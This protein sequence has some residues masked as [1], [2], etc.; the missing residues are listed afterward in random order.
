MIR[1]IGAK[2]NVYKGFLDR[3]KKISEKYGIAIQVMNAKLV[4]GK[5]HL[6]SAVEHAQRS[7]K[8][9]SNATNSLAMEILLYASGERQ[10]QKSIEKIGVKEGESELA[11]V[12]VGNF[13]EKEEKI[14]E[15]TLKDLK[16]D[17]KVLEGSLDTLKRFGFTEIELET[18]PKE[19]Q[20][21]L[22]LEK[23]AMVDVIK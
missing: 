23:V 5:D 11:F 2:G 21:D 7:F 1:V 17:D 18:I 15:E 16:R 12:F 9:G 13:K 4:Y 8:R 3:V 10:I 22:I 6:I 19:K 14:I 20:G